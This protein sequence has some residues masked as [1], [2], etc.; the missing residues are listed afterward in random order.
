MNKRIAARA[1]EKIAQ[2]EN[3]SVK[4]VRNEMIKAIRI[5]QQN[6][7]TK[8]FW[9]ERFGEGVEPSPEEL[10]IVLAGMIA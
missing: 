8:S 9:D 4:E 5:A 2:K 3:V 10:L 7:D 1:I 6:L